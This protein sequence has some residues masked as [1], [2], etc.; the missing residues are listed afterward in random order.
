MK[1]VYKTIGALACLIFV[2]C[3]FL[4][5]N[6][7]RD[8]IDEN[9][10]VQLNSGSII[11]TE[12]G[13]VV[14]YNLVNNGYT[15]L[16]NN[17]VIAAYEYNSGNYFGQNNK[18]YIV[19]Y[20]GKEKIIKDVK[21]T[22]KYFNISPDGEKMFFFREEGDNEIKILSFK[23]EEYFEFNKEVSISGKY[24]DWMDKDTIVY[25]GIRLEDKKNA[26]FQY[27]IKTKEESVLI[28]LDEG[29][30]EF[31]K[32]VDNGLVYVHN[33]ISGN[34]DLVLYDYKTGEI[35]TIIQNILKVYDVVK[36]NDYYYLL[37]RFKET[38]YSLFKVYNGE[39]KRM[40]YK[41]PDK[42]SLEKGLMKTDD[43]SV[44]FIGIDSEE[45][46]QVYQ[47][48]ENG[49]VSLLFDRVDNVTFIKKAIAQSADY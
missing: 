10:E 48:K 41:F 19:G 27:N 24:I 17:T 29:N 20:N 18:E 21:N 28:S 44:L 45:K 6:G 38:N 26:I 16:E 46:E 5:C 9:K 49:A 34:K 31:I 43:G 23:D 13:E 15:K 42:I 8:D 36:V 40:V 25:Y 30:V 7:A 33:D 4:G 11:G 2:S 3:Y 14:N 22:D 1:V 37:G 39:Y 32:S 35:S 12:D 47:C